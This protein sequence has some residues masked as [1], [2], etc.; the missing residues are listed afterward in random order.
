[1]IGASDSKHYESVATDTY[2]FLP[3]K[4]E[5]DGLERMHGTNERIEK[6][7]FIKMIGFYEILLSE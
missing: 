2:R 7:Q 1:M 4:M 5:A 6:E 3:I